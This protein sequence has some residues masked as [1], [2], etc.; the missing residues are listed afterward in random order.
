MEGST[1]K[2]AMFKCVNISIICVLHFTE[3]TCRSNREKGKKRRKVQHSTP[4]DSG[5]Q[6]LEGTQVAT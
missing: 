6:Q 2:L 1:C 4:A 3:S 5:E